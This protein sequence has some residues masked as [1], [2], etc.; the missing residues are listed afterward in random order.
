M[1]AG[2]LLRRC[3]EPPAHLPGALGP[4][5]GGA[6]GFSGPAM[7]LPGDPQ[8]PFGISKVLPGRAR[9][10]PVAFPETLGTLCERLGM[11]PELHWRCSKNVGFYR[12]R[13]LLHGWTGPG[14]SPGEPMGVPEG[15]LWEPRGAW[16]RWGGSGEALVQCGVH[17]HSSSAVTA[18]LLWVPYRLQ[19]PCGAFFGSYRSVLRDLHVHF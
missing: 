4:P 7:G 12:S 3:S 11:S 14:G 18:D 10:A 19:R 13:P 2:T 17:G 9:R 6:G 16:L 8:A 1:F 5:Q 15:T